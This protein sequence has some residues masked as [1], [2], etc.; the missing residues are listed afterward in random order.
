MPYAA[1][2]N[3]SISFN[4]VDLSNP[5]AGRVDLTVTSNRFDLLQVDVTL[6]DSNQQPVPQP[7]N[8]T[9]L[10]GYYVLPAFFDMEIANAQYSHKDS[11]A[12]PWESYGLG[13]AN[14]CP[15]HE[16]H[17]SSYDANVHIDAQDPADFHVGLF[18]GLR[19]RTQKYWPSDVDD[20]QVQLEFLALQGPA[21]CVQ[22]TALFA[23][24]AG[25]S[26]QWGA[27]EPTPNQP[28]VADFNWSCSDLDCSFNGSNSYDPDG[29]IASYSWDF[30]DGSSSSATN[31][32]HSYTAAG[33][34]QV[35][36]TV[37]DDDGTTDQSSQWITAT[38][39]PAA[40]IQ[41][42]LSTNKKRNRVTVQWTGTSANKV[43]IY[44]DAVKVTT[45]RNDGNWADGN[46]AS[47]NSYSYRVCEQNS[48]IVCSN[49]VVIDL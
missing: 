16:D 15:Y 6:L 7:G 26:N 47:G 29:S 33:D 20:Y 28:P 19:I 25:S 23:S 32:E 9:N 8:T 36:L 24:G 3:T 27:C 43:D 49:D 14:E 35:T 13:G 48:S 37:A 34:W 10:N 46:V 39:P 40:N 22:A 2:N 11:S 45:T 38:N 1:A 41:L 30:G 21:V 12:F 4:S 44:R 18:N 5:A 42:G 17:G 31:P